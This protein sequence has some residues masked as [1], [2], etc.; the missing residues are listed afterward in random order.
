MSSLVTQDRDER[1]ATATEYAL[2]GGFIAVVIATSVGFFG[3]AIAN[4]FLNFP[5]IWP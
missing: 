3:Q 4:V 5:D 2:L 1:G